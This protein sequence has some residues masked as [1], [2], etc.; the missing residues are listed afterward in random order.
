M[1]ANSGKKWFRSIY[2]F[3]IQFTIFIVSSPY[4][5]FFLLGSWKLWKSCYGEF[6]ICFLLALQ[7]FHWSRI[8]FTLIYTLEESPQTF[9]QRKLQPTPTACTG[10]PS[11]SI[12]HRRLFVHTQ[13]RAEKCI[14]VISLCQWEES[15]QFY[16]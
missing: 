11:F 2:H 9:M 6:C 12:S 4:Q 15:F 1:C 5:D 10:K 14:Q 3:L 16:H 13:P 7:E 8:S